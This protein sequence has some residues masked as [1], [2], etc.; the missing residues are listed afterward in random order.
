MPASCTRA[1]NGSKCSSPGESGPGRGE[2]RGRPHDDDAR[3]LV[4]RPLELLDGPVHVGER[5]VGRRE[6][7]VLVVEAPVFF[8]PAVE[9]PERDPDRFGVVDEQLLVEHAERREQPDR[10]ET[11]LVE[12]ADARVAVA[13]LG[14]DRL[15]LGEHLER[16]LALGVAAEVVVQRAGLGDRA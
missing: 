2:R 9:G 7:A 15:A 10:L 12:H 1:Q 16:A 5:D 4:E 13:V 6:D 8:E 3:A 14:P 11:E